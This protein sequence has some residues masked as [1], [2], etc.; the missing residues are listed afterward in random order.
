MHIELTD[1]QAEVLRDLLR[2]ALADL[3]SE[4]AATDNAGYREG[5]RT[6]R[7]SLETVLA[8]L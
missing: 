6:R 3:S 5:L 8:Q 2:G 7:Q 4:I 1:G